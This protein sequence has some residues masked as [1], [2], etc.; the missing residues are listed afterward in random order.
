MGRLDHPGVA[1]IYEAGMANRDATRLPYFVMELVEGLPLIRF[2]QE[3]GLD[4]RRRIELMIAV[5]DAVHHAHLRGVIHR[6]LK[7]P[8]ILVREDGQPKVLDFGVARITDS[9]LQLT[10]IHTEIGQILGILPYMSPEQISGR[11]QQLDL[12]SDVY[13]LGVLTF[14]LLTGRLPQPLQNCELVD[15]IRVITDEEPDTL[16]GK[17][18]RFGADLET[19]IAMCLRKEPE[20]R[21]PSAAAF[22]EDLRRYLNDEPVS[23]RPT[24][25]IYHW[26]KFAR[27]NRAIVAWASLSLVSLV[28]GL[29]VSLAGWSTACSERN[30][31][32]AAADEAIEL[33]DFLVELL[34]AP[35]PRQ[36]GA[37]VRVRDLLDRASERSTDMLE[38]RPG[39]AARVHHALGLSYRGLG[40]DQTALVELEAAVRR[41]EELRGEGGHARLIEAL[42]DLSNLRYELGAIDTADSLLDRI[43]L[44]L[45]SMD[46]KSPVRLRARL[47]RGMIASARR[48]FE[49]AES[50]LASAYEEAVAQLGSESR[51]ALDLRS[52]LAAVYWRSNQPEKARD[53]WAATLEIDTR[54]YGPDHPATLK[55]VNNLGMVYRQLEDYARAKEMLERSLISKPQLLGADHPSTAIGHHNLALVL[56]ETGES[57]DALLHHLK[58]IAIADRLFTGDDPR[59]PHFQAGY[60]GTLF[61]L[62]RYDEARAAYLGCYEPLLAIYGSEHP[63]MQGIFK[64]LEQTNDR[65]G[66]DDAA[67]KW[68]ALILESD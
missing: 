26:S 46:V 11:N 14:E 7:P 13:A 4:E 53:S 39:V 5:C 3:S 59:R 60:A 29:G 52:E 10:T 64:E 62:E 25:A 27:R 15:A 57:E 47:L 61:R 19:I 67:E 55:S 18:R 31:A 20:R 54:V 16:S 56:R 68:R 8:N 63:R 50:T 35:D 41:A 58:A 2:A 32:L 38:E 9:D 24:S 40:L 44:A 28:A 30:N 33:S 37:E 43:D 34:S 23:A 22:G 42:L 45:P 36:D 49:A 1:R 21:Y 17:G 12:R 66:D 6:D 51:I 65:L 48:E